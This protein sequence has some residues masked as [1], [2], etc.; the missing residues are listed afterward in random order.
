MDQNVEATSTDDI[1]VW[2]E[3]KA[4]N[5]EDTKEKETAARSSIKMDP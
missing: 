1:K 2:G 4:Y 5:Q 3:K